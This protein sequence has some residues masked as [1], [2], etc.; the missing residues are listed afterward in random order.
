MLAIRQPHWDLSEFC[1]VRR[2][3]T[4][5]IPLTSDQPETACSIEGVLSH[6]PPFDILRCE[7]PF[8][9]HFVPVVLRNWLFV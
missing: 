3:C 5:G 6:S 1:T 4:Q 2:I 8:S 7:T 9:M